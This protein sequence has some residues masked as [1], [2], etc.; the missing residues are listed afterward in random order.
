MLKKTDFV[1]NIL[2]EK[3][4][5]VAELNILLITYK[6]EEK[7]DLYT[8]KKTES[9]YSK[10]KTYNICSKSGELGPKRKQG[11]YQVPE[12]FYYIDRFNPSSNF[13]LSLGLNYPNQADRKKSSYPNLGGDIFIHGDCVTIGCMP[14][15][16]DKIK[17]IYLYAVH[18]RNNGQLKIPVYVLPFK[19]TAEN[20]DIYASDINYV[21][22]KSFW[23]NLK[24]GYDQFIS[25]KKELEF[26]VDKY[27]N[28]TF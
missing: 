10:I 28:Y 15:T 20:L 17:E 7:L 14:M 1:T 19:M 16:D 11:D 22:F 4:I 9:I 6:A 8:K 21:E 5:N 13:Y 24:N 3:G 12:G 27:G 18:A 2:K 25:N 23:S 26:S